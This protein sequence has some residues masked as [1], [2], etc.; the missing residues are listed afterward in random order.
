MRAAGPLLSTCPLVLDSARSIIHVLVE[1]VSSPDAPWRSLAAPKDIPS[2]IPSHPNPSTSLFP[3]NARKCRRMP[4][5]QPSRKAGIVSQTRSMGIVPGIPRL[6]PASPTAQLDR[7]PCN[8]PQKEQCVRSVGHCGTICLSGRE[9]RVTESAV[10][11][12]RR[13]KE[14]KYGSQLH[15]RDWA[16]DMRVV[17]VLRLRRVSRV[18]PPELAEPA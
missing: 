1:Q 3:L 9:G 16:R 11:E 7:C 17:S 13:Y 6:D 5:R 10:A 18:L 2:S 15:R 12:D 4:E 14:N 8:T